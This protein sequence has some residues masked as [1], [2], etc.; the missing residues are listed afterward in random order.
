MVGSTTV[1]VSSTT[2]GSG[3]RDTSVMAASRPKEPAGGTTSSAPDV[4]GHLEPFLAKLYIAHSCV[5]EICYCVCV[6]VC[7]YVCV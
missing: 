4:S 6:Y 5:C 2:L 1:Y 7:V 3:G